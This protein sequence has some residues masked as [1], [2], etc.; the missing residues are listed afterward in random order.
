MKEAAIIRQRIIAGER[1]SDLATE[2]GASRAAIN[3]IAKNKAYKE[4]P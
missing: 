2:Y 1:Q 4:Q 3:R